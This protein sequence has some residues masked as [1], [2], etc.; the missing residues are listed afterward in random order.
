MAYPSFPVIDKSLR[1]KYTAKE[2]QMFSDVF[3]FDKCRYLYET[4][5]S[6]H[7]SEFAMKELWQQMVFRM[8]ADGLRKHIAFV[9]NDMFWFCNVA[10]VNAQIPG[11]TD[12]YASSHSYIP[13]REVLGFVYFKENG[14]RLVK[15]G[16]LMAAIKCYNACQELCPENATIY[17][18]KAFCALKMNRPQEVLANCEKALELE[19]NNIKALYRQG[20]A[21]KALK[22]FEK[23]VKNFEKILSIEKNS[24]AERELENIMRRF[25]DKNKK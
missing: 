7:F 1:L 17:N 16:K 19:P 2:R 3:I 20:M 24:D 10:S 8:V 4:F 25:G 18:N 9:Y 11:G 13:D 23:A 22:E 21:W 5:P 14:N 12:F 6:I 15:E